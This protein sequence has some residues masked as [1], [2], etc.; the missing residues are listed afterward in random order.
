[1]NE[2]RDRKGQSKDS[3]TWCFLQVLR[4]KFKR[5]MMLSIIITVTSILLMRR[6]ISYARG[7]DSVVWTSVCF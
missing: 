5:F 1:M 3:V 7:E 4:E 6:Y 2:E